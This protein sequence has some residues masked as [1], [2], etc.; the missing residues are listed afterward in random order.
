MTMGEIANCPK[1]NALFVQSQLRSICEACFK[2][3]EKAYDTVYKFLRK[4]ENRN[5]ILHEIVGGTGVEEE[6]LLKFIRTG[7]ILLSNFPNLGYPCEKCGKEIRKDRLCEGCKDNIQKQLHQ[8]EQEEKII[9][10]NR[11]KERSTTF[12]TQKSKK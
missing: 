3:E 4:R 2:A 9:D 7:R 8:I 1:C 10:R 11:V 5:S 6:L 12:Y